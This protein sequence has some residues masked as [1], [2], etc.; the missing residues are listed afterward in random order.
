[1]TP[2]EHREKDDSEEPL[3]SVARTIDQLITADISGRGAIGTLYPAA[4]ALS[5]KPL[6]L[7]AAN[8]LQ[9]ALSTKDVVFIATGWP[10][11]PTIDL[12]IAETDGPVG[13]AVL[14]RALHCAFGVVPI[15]LTE[16]SLADSVSTIISSTG[17]RM[18]PPDLALSAGKIN[19]PLHAA[20]V[21]PLPTT[22]EKAKR[23]SKRLCDNYAPGAVVAI[24]KAGMNESGITYSCRGEEAT[25]TTAKVDYLILEARKRGIFTL[26]I[27]DGGNEIG[28]GLI[29]E[30]ADEVLTRSIGRK[31]PGGFASSVHTDAVLVATISNWG[32]Y[33]IAAMLAFLLQQR[34]IFHDGQIEQR[35]LEGCAQ[36]GFIDGVT[37][38]VDGSVDGIPLNIHLAMVSVLKYL[39]E[40]SLERSQ[41]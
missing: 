13:A 30:A 11:R 10:D 15:I 38:Y 28:M 1:M 25:E 4:R 33:G 12:S 9:H 41:G 2:I 21:L 36:A 22:A 16:E 3:F 27:G 34:G 26:G 23:E 7:N 19:A 5:E 6:V 37:G 39:V 31:V 8:S 17:F 20:A 32:A 35:V 14:A 40:R 18:L 29:H 24:E